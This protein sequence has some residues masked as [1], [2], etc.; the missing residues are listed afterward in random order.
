MTTRQLNKQKVDFTKNGQIWP[1]TVEV[2]V[3]SSDFWVSTAVTFFPLRSGAV[4][5]TTRRV[6]QKRP[7]PARFAGGD[8]N[9]TEEDLTGVF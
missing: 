4:A 9:E 8:I 6:N 3:I 7:S 2:T 5:R 1:S